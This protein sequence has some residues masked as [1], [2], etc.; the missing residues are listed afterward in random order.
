MILHK[1]QNQALGLAKAKQ[2]YGRRSKGGW[3]TGLQHNVGE[4]IG[5]VCYGDRGGAHPQAESSCDYYWKRDGN[6]LSVTEMVMQT[7]EISIR[8][9]HEFAWSLSL[10]ETITRIPSCGTRHGHNHN[11]RNFNIRSN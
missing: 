1:P 7:S 6:I 8:L 10:H 11:P 5:N 2:V 3:T 9:P 4:Y